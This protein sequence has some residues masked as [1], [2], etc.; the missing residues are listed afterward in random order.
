MSFSNNFITPIMHSLLRCE[1]TPIRSYVSNV[2]VMNTCSMF[3]TSLLE[4]ASF[5][6]TTFQ[7]S[8]LLSLKKKQ[9]HCSTRKYKRFWH[10]LQLVAK[11]Y[12][13][14]ACVISYIGW[15]TLLIFSLHPFTPKNYNMGLHSTLIKSKNAFKYSNIVHTYV[16]SIKSW[17]VKYQGNCTIICV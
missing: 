5:C 11:C 16:C 2:V 8:F 10:D 7:P 14:Q 3:A 9:L 17:L 1:K 12:C 15:V 13:K 6:K 4:W